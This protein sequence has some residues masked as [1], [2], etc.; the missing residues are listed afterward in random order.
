[1]NAADLAERFQN[2]FHAQPEVFRAPGRVNLIGE[3]TDYNDGF[4][5]PSAVGF[6]TR[7]AVS[8]RSDRK[9]VLRSAEYPDVF[10][11]A[12]TNLPTVP[13]NA[14]CD[15]VSGVESIVQQDGGAGAGR[16]SRGHGV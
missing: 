10:G 4:V 13:L 5:M 8:A 15:Y 2:E 7:V 14:C 11:V 12:L 6:F 1:M 3:H 16:K 9:L